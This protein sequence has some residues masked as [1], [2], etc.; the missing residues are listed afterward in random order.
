VVPI[1]DASPQLPVPPVR[2][3]APAS[4]PP[5]PPPLITPRTNN[6][7][8]HEDVGDDEEEGF[9][10]VDDYDFTLPPSIARRVVSITPDTVIHSKPHSGNSQQQQQQY[11]LQQ[12]PPPHGAGNTRPPIIKASRT[13]SLDDHYD[14]GQ[15][16]GVGAF[17]VV[18]VGIHRASQ[19][20]YAIKRIDRS[21]MFWADRDA[22]EDEISNL[23]LVR[24]GP[25][26]VQLYEVYE[27]LSICYLVMELLEGGELFHRILQKKT[28]TE[29]EARD[30]CLCI[31]QALEYMHERRVAHRDLKPENLLLRVRGILLS[32]GMRVCCYS[33]GRCLC[34][35]KRL[36]NDGASHNRLDVLL[37][38]VCTLTCVEF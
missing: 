12:P 24:Q 10:N 29:R 13:I 14:R 25:H 6:N 15:N 1:V 35:S 7:E 8:K 38:G 5:L 28:F 20:L 17:A 11:P 9:A 3:H 30:V 4:R 33:L 23:K 27:E 32:D 21:K 19:Q 36:L 22:L 31:L 37:L 16:L 2:T 34:A 18:F 26:I